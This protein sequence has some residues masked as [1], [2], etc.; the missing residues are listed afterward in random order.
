MDIMMLPLLYNIGSDRIQKYI[1]K[2]LP[3]N[4]GCINFNRM[5]VLLPEL[6]N[7]DIR[8]FLGCQ[9]KSF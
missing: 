7:F 2:L 8:I 4:R 9:I 5:I 6:K 1:I 3:P